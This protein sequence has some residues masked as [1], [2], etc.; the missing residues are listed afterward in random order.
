MSPKI[1][2]I[3]S[4]IIYIIMSL[5]GTYISERNEKLPDTPDSLPLLY[6]EIFYH[7]INIVVGI[8]C[9]IHLIKWIFQ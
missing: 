4:F 7:F 1:I 6:A 8:I 5:I 2:C 9:I 3:I